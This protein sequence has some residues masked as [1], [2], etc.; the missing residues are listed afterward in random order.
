MVSAGFTLVEILVAVTIFTVIV[1][2]GVYMSMSSYQGTSFRS[3]RDVIVSVLE[4]ARSH[5]VNNLFQSAYSVCFDNVGYNYIIVRGTVYSAGAATNDLVS[6]SKGILL[7][8]GMPLCGSG[9]IGFEQLTGKLIP[10]QASAPFELTFTVT[11][12]NRTSTIAI[13]NEG[14]INW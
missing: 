1:S 12:N 3:E 6:A 7:S 4:K 2:I 11:A 5:G 8:A 13:N 14:R 10:P 9:S